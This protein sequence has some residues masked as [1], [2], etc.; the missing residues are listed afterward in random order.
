MA[1]N[2]KKFNVRECVEKVMEQL[3][4]GEV[5]SSYSVRGGGHTKLGSK[6]RPKLKYGGNGQGN[7]HI[8]YVHCGS[9]IGKHTAYVVPVDP[10]SLEASIAEYRA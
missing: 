7:Q 9:D 10:S 8:L 6:K 1:K 2:N 4:A 5:I 3:K